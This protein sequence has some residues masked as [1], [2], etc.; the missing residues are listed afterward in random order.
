MSSNISKR[1]FN[2]NE[3]LRMAESGILAPSER[4]ELIGGEILVMS[5]VGPRHNAAVSATTE[6]IVERSARRVNVWP[7]NSVL[8]H[9]FA[10]PL[11]DIALLRRR[12]DFYAGQLPA[13][14]DIL[15]IIEVADSSLEFDTTVKLALY[16]IIGI[17]EYWVADLQNN[18]LL[19]YS[20]PESDTYS[21]LR[22]LHRGDSIAPLLLPD[23]DIPVDLLLPR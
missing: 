3:C 1:L 19:V 11:P 6:A 21:A 18:R 17:V 7:Q 22:E 5:P 13:P 23:C 20:K 12:E 4:V 15:L 10:A 2:F 16:A 14:T 8:L 9:E